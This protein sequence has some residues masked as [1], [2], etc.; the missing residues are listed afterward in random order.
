LLGLGALGLFLI[1]MLGAMAIG[2][3]SHKGINAGYVLLGV[4]I[5]AVLVGLLRGGW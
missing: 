1:V 3:S 2:Y 4:L 5:G